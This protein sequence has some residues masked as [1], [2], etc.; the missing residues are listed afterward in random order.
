MT[1]DWQLYFPSKGRRA[2]DFF[3]LNI[4]RLWPGANSH[5]WVPK[6]STLPLDR[7]S[8]C[9]TIYL[10]ISLFCWTS[11]NAFSRKTAVYKWYCVQCCIAALHTVSFVHGCFAGKC[12]L[13]GS[14]EQRY[15]KVDGSMD[16]QESQ[17][18]TWVVA[19][20]KKK[21]AAWRKSGL[22]LSQQTWKDSL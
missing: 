4:R 16:C 21:M 7:R 18:S 9:A 17:D 22:L 5:T 10:E 8:C 14:T 1:W 15:F 13:T 6:A 3:A 19:L 2:E 20:T 11:Q 12:I